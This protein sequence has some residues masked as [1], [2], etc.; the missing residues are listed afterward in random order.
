M[1]E[2][3]VSKAL[4]RRMSCKNSHLYMAAE[5]SVLV[6]QSIITFLNG[7]FFIVSSLALGYISRTMESSVQL[8]V[9]YSEM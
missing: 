7:M 8:Q 3:A 1:W 2:N 5:T 4:M 6:L 9:C